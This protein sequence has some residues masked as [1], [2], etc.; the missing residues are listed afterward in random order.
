VKDVAKPAANAIGPNLCSA[1][2]APNTTGVRGNTHG[3]R[4]E[5]NPANSANGTVVIPIV[6]TWPFAEA[7]R[8]LRAGSHRPSVQLHFCPDKQRAL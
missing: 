8:S 7:P 6:L 4:I 3:D 5:N 2:A 1:T